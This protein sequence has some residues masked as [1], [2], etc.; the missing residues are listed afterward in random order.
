MAEQFLHD[1]DV[2]ATFHEVSRERM[3]EGV[4]SN[5]A[6]DARRQV[7]AGSERHD[8]IIAD[9][10]HPARSGSGALYTVEHFAAVR[11]RLAD[12]GLFCQW[13]PLHQLDLDSLR[14]KPPRTRSQDIGQ[15]IVNL[16]GMTKRD[17]IA[18]LIHGVSLS[19]RGSGRLD[20]RLDTPP[21]IKRRHPDSC[22]AP[23][24][25]YR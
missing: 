1:A 12:N 21:S 18:S 15:C 7:R 19:S 6:A 4:R 24:S 23:V 13:L 25:L 16:V 8:L 11:E 5:V 22:L 14:K 17:N 9:N 10:F 3:P 2:G 20:T